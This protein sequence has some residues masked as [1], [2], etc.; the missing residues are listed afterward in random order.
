[1]LKNISANI[2]SF[3]IYLLPFTGKVALSAKICH[4]AKRKD[5]QNVAGDLQK[6]LN[7]IKLNTIKSSK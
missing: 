5:W 2:A 3:F 7:T 1:M 4:D 6:A